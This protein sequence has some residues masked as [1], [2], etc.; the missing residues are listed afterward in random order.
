MRLRSQGAPPQVKNSR[1]KSVAFLTFT[2]CSKLLAPWALAACLVACNTP[3]EPTWATYFDKANKISTQ[4]EFERWDKEAKLVYQESNQYGGKL[5]PRSRL[6]GWTYP[7][8]LHDLGN[9]YRFAR[10]HEDAERFYAKALQMENLEY[11]DK[12]NGTYRTS[13]IAML[14]ANGKTKEAVEEQKQLIAAIE[15][16]L[17]TRAYKGSPSHQEWLAKEQATLADMEKQTVP[18]KKVTASPEVK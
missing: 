4:K 2:S 3:P 9:S 18:S 16:E 14:V 12:S 1:N 11:P 15:K 5:P 6:Y 7:S 8:A 10:K 17:T 13:L